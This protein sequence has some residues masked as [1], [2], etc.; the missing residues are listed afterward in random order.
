MRKVKNT[1][2]RR[3]VVTG[4]YAKW[5]LIVLAAGSLWSAAARPQYYNSCSTPSSNP[6]TG[7]AITST[8]DVD[9]TLRDSENNVVTEFIPGAL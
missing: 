8:S 5:L 1:L 6:M 7:S 3:G 4:D 2:G 9:Y